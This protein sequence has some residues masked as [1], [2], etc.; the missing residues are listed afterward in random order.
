[1]TVECFASKGHLFH[2]SASRLRDHYRKSLRMRVQEG[3]RKSVLWTGRGNSTQKCSMYAFMR[4]TQEHSSEHPS[5]VCERDHELWLQTLQTVDDFWEKSLFSFWMWLLVGLPCS[6]G[7][8]YTQEYMGSTNWSWR[9][10]K[11]KR[12]VYMKLRGMEV[13]A[14]LWSIIERNGCD[15]DQ[16][17]C[18]CISNN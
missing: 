3:W 10:I 6:C 7:L 8:S 16:K 9:V 14:N 13:E 2:T 11:K 4:E 5:I 15:Y 17:C 18:H 12:H 1:M